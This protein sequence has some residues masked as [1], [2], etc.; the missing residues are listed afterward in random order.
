MTAIFFSIHTIFQPP[1]FSAPIMNQFDRIYALHA[2]FLS[3]RYP[4]SKNTLMERMECS[5]PTIKRILKKMRD[6]L[7]TPVRYDKRHDG[8]VLDHAQKDSDEESRHELPG[9]W[10]TVSELHALL[11]VHELI[12]RIQP[13]LL[14]KEFALIRGRVESILERQNLAAN[15]IFRRFRFHSVGARPCPPE[16]FHAAASATLQRRRLSL[17]YRDRVRD[18]LSSR[19]VSPQQLIYYRENWYLRAWCHKSDDFRTF[20]LDRVQRLDILEEQALDMDDQQ[21]DDHHARAFGIFSGPA[22]KMAVLRFSRERARWIVAEQWHPDQ[23]GRWLDDGSYQLCLPYGD[24]R[25]LILDILRYG[26]DVEVMAPPSLRQEVK[27]KLL[28]AL[29]WYG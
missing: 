9:L 15:E 18:T 14:R 6:E 16:N 24:S 8:Y 12:S 20:A 26:P 29:G 11:T 1:D 5:W 23:E 19:T 4:L 2:L 22:D 27:D 17:S 3:H 25:E 13:G 7:G 10:F 21:P 28:A